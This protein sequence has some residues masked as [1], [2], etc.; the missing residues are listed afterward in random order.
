LVGFGGVDLELVV[1]EW[2]VGVN[3][4]E[5]KLLVVEVAVVGLCGVEVAFVGFPVLPPVAVAVVVAGDE[6]VP[7]EFFDTRAAKPGLLPCAKS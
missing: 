3:V 7:S 2:L 6:A 5:V 1:D 4:T